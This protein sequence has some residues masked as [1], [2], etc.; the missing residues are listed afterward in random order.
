MT[1]NQSKAPTSGEKQ[2]VAQTPVFVGRMAMSKFAYVLIGLMF[3]SIAKAADNPDWA[4]PVN[5][6][7]AQLDNVTLRSLPGSA[8]QYTEAQIDDQFNP[9][10]WYP[11]QHSPLPPVVASGGTRPRVACG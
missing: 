5:P 2:R 7:P 8:K 6:P 1:G 11:E 4:Y 9:P 3:C 10:D